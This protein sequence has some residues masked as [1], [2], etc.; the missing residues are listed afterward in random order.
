V[1]KPVPVRRSGG[2]PIGCQVGGTHRGS[3]TVLAAGLLFL[4]GILSLIAVD[5]M[6]A[7]GARARAQLAA[8]AA[9]LAAAQEMA[10]AGDAGPSAVAL[11][12]A[13]LNGAELVW[14]RCPSD[15][16][17]A[18]VEVRVHF[19]TVFL[20]GERQTTA[21]AR[22]VVESGGEQLTGL[23]TPGGPAVQRSPHGGASFPKVAPWRSARNEA[24]G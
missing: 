5:L 12:Y 21:R 13:G 8:D 24:D 6:R 7:V 4:A 10:L 18:V 15:G 20:G 14:C 22:A 16:M 2:K 9:A 23:T 19:A 11:E 3:V 1:S 17:E